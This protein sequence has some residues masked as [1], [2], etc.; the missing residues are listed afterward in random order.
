MRKLLTGK[1]R[2]IFNFVR[3]K[4]HEGLPPSLD[5]IAD[6]FGFSKTYAA[7]VINALEKKRYIDFGLRRRRAISLLPPYKDDTRC[8][9]L[10]DTDI[11]QLNIR[12]GDFLLI[13]TGKPVADGD[14]IL[15]SQGE[16]KRFTPGDVAFGKVVSF[17]REI[18][19]HAFTTP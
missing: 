7:Q 11:P 5:E 13:D 19:S 4:I 14:V 17:A 1:Q 12:K 6:H 2:V 10:A 15:S 16:I 18:D 9:L 8:S 3:Q